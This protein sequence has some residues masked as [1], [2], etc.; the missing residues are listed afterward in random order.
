MRSTLVIV[1]LFAIAL[2]VGQAPSGPS[3]F[4]STKVEATVV[5]ALNKAGMQDVAITVLKPTYSHDLLRAQIAR[6]GQEM[7]FQPRGLQI[8]DYS[9]NPSDPSA[10]TVR[11]TFG[12]AGLMEPAEGVLH[13]QPLVRALSLAQAPDSLE[14]LMIEFQGQAPTPNTIKSCFPPAPGCAGVELEGRAEGSGPLAGVEY[15][16]KLLTHDPDKIT[17]P[18]RPQSP[19]LESS[20]KPE[21]KGLDYTLIGLIGIAA[22]AVGALVYSLLLRGRPVRRA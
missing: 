4:A 9:F 13:L 2:A 17:V 16:V 21:K 6:L 15:R 11:A 19:K 18:D 5:V 8:T 12:M 22:V 1:C 14:G 3:L 7:G 10:R 20:P